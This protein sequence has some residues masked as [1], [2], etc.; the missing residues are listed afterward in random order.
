MKIEIVPETR[1]TKK[2]KGSGGGEG[3]FQWV[4]DTIF[5]SVHS[6]VEGVTKSVAD[7]VED[8]ANRIAQKAVLA[9]LISLG[10]F[11]L[12]QGFSKILNVLYGMPG[13]G[14]TVVGFL[15]LAAAFIFAVVWKKQ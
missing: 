5:G 15:V 11:F 1:K 8:V 9:A 12:L 13:M 2:E 10:F 6:F 7:S 4:F 14:E 3:M